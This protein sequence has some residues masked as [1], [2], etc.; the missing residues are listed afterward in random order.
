MAN[1]QEK[2]SA[3]DILSKMTPEQKIRE[4]NGIDNYKS[5]IFKDLIHT[6]L[7]GKSIHTPS[8]GNKK[9]GIPYPILGRWT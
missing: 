8:G 4:L 6:G 7:T 9:L 1:A 2:V 3:E 5:H